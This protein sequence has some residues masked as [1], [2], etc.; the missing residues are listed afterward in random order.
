MTILEV[1][2]TEYAP[3]YANYINQVP[4]EN[5]L[6]EE[7]ES[8]LHALINFV[9]KIPSDKFDYRYAEGKWTL[10][11]ILQHLIDTERIFVYRALR[12]ARKDQTPLPGF[13]ENRY[14]DFAYANQREVNDLM[15]EF[16]IVRQSTIH[17]FRTFTDEQLSFMGTASEK[18]VSVRAI[19]F[20]ICGHQ[21]HH[22]NIFKERYLVNNFSE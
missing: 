12:I 15:E 13:D 10:K 22:L 20:I 14:V 3:F 1:R 11:D 2:P 17:L 6:L 21:K 18:P 4:K 7:L 5:E 9:D 8:T 19:G 16:K